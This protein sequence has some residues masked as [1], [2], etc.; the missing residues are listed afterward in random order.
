MTLDEGGVGIL[1]LADLANVWFGFS[2]FAIENC[3]FFGFGVF[4]GL[5]VFSNLV[6]GFR[7]SSKMLAVFR[8]F[9][10]VY[11]TAS[12]VLQMKLYPAVAL[13]PVSIGILRIY[14]GD[15]DA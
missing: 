1:G 4:Y 8:I 6:F 11:F 7:F 13:K 14:D 15:D 5:R 9:C 3:G 2:V 12:L 10:S